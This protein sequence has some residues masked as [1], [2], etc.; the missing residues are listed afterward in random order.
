VKRT[1]TDEQIAIF[2][3]SEIEALLRDHRHAKEAVEHESPDI[4]VAESMMDETV[5]GQGWSPAD[6]H[7]EPMAEGRLEDGELD[8]DTAPQPPRNQ[9]NKNNKRKKKKNGNKSERTPQPKGFFKQTVKPDLRKRTWDMVDT[10]LANLD[11]DED[12]SAT[13]V[14]THAAQRRRISYDDD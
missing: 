10:G 8:E 3:H 4:Q 14:P 6:K 2:R 5:F 7:T 13:S 1:L 9:N 12:N 11:Y